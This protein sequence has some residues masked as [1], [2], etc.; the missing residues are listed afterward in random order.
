MNNMTADEPTRL[1]QL[2]QENATLR[3]QLESA[4]M[5]FRKLAP[6]IGKAAEATAKIY[7]T[8]L[9]NICSHT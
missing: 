6:F 2:E 7:E 8:S 4:I 9:K 3:E 5:D 1:Q